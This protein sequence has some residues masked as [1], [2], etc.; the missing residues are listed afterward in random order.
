VG[1]V[2]KFARVV[3]RCT[4]RFVPHRH[5]EWAAAL[6][7]EL[8]FIESDW[9]ALGW[10]L[11]G[12]TALV[13]RSWAA[14]GHGALVWLGIDS[15][16]W[17]EQAM[18]QQAKK[19]GLLLLGALGAFAVVAVMFGLL[20]GLAV[21]FPSLGLDRAEWTHWLMVIVIPMMIC[22]AA[23]I[24]LWRRKKPVAVGILLTAVAF[25]THIALHFAHHWNGQ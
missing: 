1:A 17:K 24:W 3:V 13:R 10:A 19:A 9:A 4:A 2:H 25:G 15:Q 20:F 12:V 8:D 5:Q 18:E 14:V 6:L 21:T 16:S 7:A 22:A 11:G 23:A